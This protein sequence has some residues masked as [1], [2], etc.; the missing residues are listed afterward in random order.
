[1]GVGVGAA[2]GDGVGIEVGV[3]VVFGAGEGDGG[4]RIE[5]NLSLGGI[6]EGF[7]EPNKGASSPAS[8]SLSR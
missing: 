6:E 4:G 7:L 3:G 2:D 1:V 5:G 8:R